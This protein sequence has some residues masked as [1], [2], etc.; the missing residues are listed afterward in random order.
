MKNLVAATEEELQNIPDI[1]PIVAKNIVDFFADK[2]NQQVIDNLRAA[3]VQWSEVEPNRS[4]NTDDLI[5]SGK[6]VV[7]TGTLESMSRSDA[8]KKLQALGAKV[9]GSVSAK[10]S[11]VVVGNEPGSKATKAAELGVEN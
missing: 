10:T 1:G 11:F 6:T 5:L 4:V 7:L 8:K 3:G 9:T 2:K